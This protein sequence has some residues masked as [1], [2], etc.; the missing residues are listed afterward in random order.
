MTQ[1]QRAEKSLKE[2]QGEQLI[3]IG[4]LPRLCG[5]EEE[6][7]EEKRAAESVIEGTNQ[8]VKVTLAKLEQNGMFLL[9]RYTLH[10]FSC[11]FMIW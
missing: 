5:K 9:E 4:L 10:L 2:V 1:C 11:C 3:Y 6:E 8:T 7:R